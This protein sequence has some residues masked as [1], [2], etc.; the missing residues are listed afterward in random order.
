MTRQVFDAYQIRLDSRVSELLQA[1]A[2]D[3]GTTVPNLIVQLIHD[4][5]LACAR[6]MHGDEFV[7]A[8]E[9]GAQR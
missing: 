5:L 6:K 4:H 3:R 8:V 9:M 2:A 1:D 7:L